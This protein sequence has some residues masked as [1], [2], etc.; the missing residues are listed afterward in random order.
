MIYLTF[1]KITK[2]KLLLLHFGRVEMEP[3][4][5][6]KCVDQYN[7]QNPCSILGYL[8]FLIYWQLLI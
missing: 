1:S 5:L 7:I 3:N 6:A 8:R 2:G 4:A